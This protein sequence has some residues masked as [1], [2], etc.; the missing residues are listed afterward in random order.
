MFRSSRL[1][2]SVLQQLNEV[3]AGQPGLEAF[4]NGVADQLAGALGLHRAAAIVRDVRHERSEPLA[5]IDQSFA[6]EL[7]VG[8]LD[9]D[10]ADEQVLGQAA[11]RR[12]RRTRRQAAFADLTLQSVND[13]LIE[14][15]ASRG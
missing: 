10:D 14:R 6:L 11:E 13:L 1:R 3:F 7:F 8:A 2:Q 15:D 4:A 12:E 5:A 9:G